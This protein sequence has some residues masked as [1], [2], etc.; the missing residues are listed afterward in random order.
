MQGFCCSTLIDIASNLSNL[1]VI[2]IY[3]YVGTIIGELKMNITEYDRITAGRNIGFL[4][5]VVRFLGFK[6]FG[7]FLKV[8]FRFF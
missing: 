2:F 8:C 7:V 5:K 4:E 3:F 1:S 6:F